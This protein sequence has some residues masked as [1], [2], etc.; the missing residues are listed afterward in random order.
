[1]KKIRWIVIIFAL[2][3]CN[4]DH[5]KE[6]ISKY[7]HYIWKRQSG[8]IE[9]N[10]LKEIKSITGKDSVEILIDEYTKDIHPT[11]PLD[12]ILAHINNDIEYNSNLLTQANNQM[13]SLTSYQKKV[14]ANDEVINALVKSSKDLI[15]LTTQQIEEL[16]Y[17][18]SAFKKFSRDEDAV[19]GYEVLCNYRVKGRQ[20][21]TTSKVITQT[22]YLSPDT[23]KIFLVK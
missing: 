14:D 2:G 17:Y 18:R 13:D 8:E 12:T 5:K 4:G 9:I 1:M 23:R 6:T 22:F 11:P 15:K 10:Q 7:I 20:P 21:D 3:S 16:K 19:V